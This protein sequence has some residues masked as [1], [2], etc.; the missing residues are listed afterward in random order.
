MLRLIA[1]AFVFALIPSPSSSQGMRDAM[2]SY[3]SSKAF[4]DTPG[5]TVPDYAVYGNGDVH[6]CLNSGNCL[7]GTLYGKLGKRFRDAP[8]LREFYIENGNLL[9]EYWCVEGG[10]MQC[11]GSVEKDVYFPF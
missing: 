4:T 10:Y 9:V 6:L 8:Y 1:A 11:D 7:D 2:N 5:S 3:S